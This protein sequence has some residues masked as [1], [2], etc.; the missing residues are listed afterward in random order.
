MSE[1]KID[2][3]AMFNIRNYSPE[4]FEELN[5]LWELTGVGG[6]HRGDTAEVIQNTLEH[7][8][9]LI[10]LEHLSDRKIAGSAWLT[11]DS[12]RIYLHHFCIDTL[13]QGK[14][15]SHYLCEQCIEFAKSLNMQIK[16]EV[17]R[18]NSKAVALYEKHGFNYLGDYLVYIIRNTSNQ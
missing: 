9:K 2:I 18:S 8:G 3:K 13:Y 14:G 1:N 6:S 10:I 7:G 15:L 16:L 11:N 17:H 12:R 4:D 5:M